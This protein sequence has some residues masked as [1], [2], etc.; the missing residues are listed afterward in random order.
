MKLDVPPPPHDGRVYIFCITCKAR[1]TEAEGKRK[2]NG[3]TVFVCP[4]GHQN[5]RTLYYGGVKFWIADDKELW[6]ESVGV[7]VR[8]KDGKY[9]FSERTEFPFGLAVPAG[10]VDED[11]EADNAAARELEEESGIKADHLKLLFTTDIYGDSCSGGSDI[12]RWNVYGYDLREGQK[13]HLND[14]GEKELWLSL[15]EARKKE[16][17]FLIRYIFEHFYEKIS[18]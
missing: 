6:H 17:P 12:H 18:N 11:E 4:N 14:E 8:R 13:V 15:A 3:Q 16:S 1:T 10:H 5:T 7:F 2:I 9:L